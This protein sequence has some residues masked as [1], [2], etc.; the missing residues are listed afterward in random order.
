MGLEDEWEIESGD[1]IDE[2][3]LVDI[4]DFVVVDGDYLMDDVIENVDREVL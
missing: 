3:V 2:E 4:M 1:S